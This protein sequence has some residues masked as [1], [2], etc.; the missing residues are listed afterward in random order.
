M[1]AELIAA[2]LLVAEATLSLLT[3]RRRG[4][5]VAEAVAFLLLAALLATADFAELASALAGAPKPLFSLE[6]TER[7]GRGVLEEADRTVSSALTWS[8]A[9]AAAS[10]IAFTVLLAASI[11]TGG[12][13]VVAAALSYSGLAFVQALVN[14]ALA[15]AMTYRFLGQLCIAVAKAGKAAKALL[16]LGGALMVPKATRKVGATLSAVCVGLSLVIPAALN[17]VIRPVGAWENA[18]EVGELGLVKFEPLLR[19][20]VARADGAGWRRLRVEWVD[21][22]APPGLAV[23]YEDSR[24]RVIVRQSGRWF[25][26]L[27]SE[28]RVVG[29][30]YGTYW[31]PA[32]RPVFRVEA[33]G[34]ASLSCYASDLSTAPACVPTAENFTLV[35]FKLAGEGVSLVLFRD[36]SSWGAQAR[37][38]GLWVGKGFFVLEGSGMR[39]PP[40]WWY[41][42]SGYLEN[43]DVV[44]VLDPLFC[45]A[46]KGF[47]RPPPELGLG[48]PAP[49]ATVEYVEVVAWIQG[50]VDYDDLC[51]GGQPKVVDAGESVVEINGTAY[52]LRP[53]LSCVTSF[54]YLPLR[55][56]REDLARWFDHFARLANASLPPTRAAAGANRCLYGNGS[57][58]YA[59]VWNGGV[60]Y[61]QSV[62]PLERAPKIVITARYYGKLT[63]PAVVGPL[64]ARAVARGF[65]L[66]LNLV[67]GVGECPNDLALSGYDVMN[68]SVVL[69][70][71]Y[72]TLLE[73]YIGGGVVRSLRESLHDI[74]GCVN[75]LTLTAAVLLAA[76]IGVSLL[77]SALGGV[78]AFPSPL[79]SPLGYPFHALREVGAAL[80]SLARS[81]V[82]ALVFRGARTR[83]ARGTFFEE[84]YNVLREIERELRSLRELS[85]APHTRWRTLRRGLKRALGF[86]LGYSSAH[87]LPFALRVASEV[88]SRKAL[89]M[90]PREYPY[91]ERLRLAFMHPT[92][93]R[94]LF[95][96]DV[97]YALS[98]ILDAKPFTAPFSAGFIKSLKK[99]YRLLH[100]KRLKLD[101]FINAFIMGPSSRSELE[102]ALAKLAKG[103]LK[104]RASEKDLRR[105]SGALARVALPYSILETIG[106]RLAG[107][108]DELAWKVAALAAQLRFRKPELL[109]LARSRPAVALRLA[110][111]AALGQLNVSGP[112]K[113]AVFE[114]LSKLERGGVELASTWLSCMERGDTWRYLALRVAFEPGGR[115]WFL[116]ELPAQVEALVKNLAEAWRSGVGAAP[117]ELVRGLAAGFGEFEERLF[118]GFA[119]ALRGLG[120]DLHTAAEA[121][122]LSG[123]PYWAGYAVMLA[124]ESGSLD[125]LVRAVVEVISRV[126]PPQESVYREELA[127]VKSFFERAYRELSRA[128]KLV[129][130][131]LL[132]LTRSELSPDPGLSL[133]LL[134]DAEARAARSKELLWD[135]LS[136]INEALN[137]VTALTAEVNEVGLKVRLLE[138]AGFKGWRESLLKLEALLAST[139]S[140]LEDLRLKIKFS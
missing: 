14:A 106:G 138:G 124:V 121:L 123:D 33:G 59:L 77:S 36:T 113:A 39:G 68:E 103:L 129:E 62:W 120:A 32:E 134:A 49:N 66:R 70:L 110:D 40:L 82:E 26:E 91:A 47:G 4:E 131:G 132:S 37:G 72:D 99:E 20:P 84:A 114:G 50:D 83:I 109:E 2:F 28:Y 64:P 16:P 102:R 73:E 93:A 81:V 9:A 87:P 8:Q 45:D 11:L 80:T 107:S 63:K 15:V 104:G 111:L 51:A 13:V 117:Q 125:E 52:R 34:Y 61:S 71:A 25:T 53:E 78:P 76:A 74:L 5:R 85:S 43:H 1:S 24:G 12:A 3:A 135:L 136:R 17:A 60:L 27:A 116:S 95:A 88:A 86:A 94:L 65:A 112:W 90:V 23:V 31:L 89:S 100:P 21:V 35:R 92:A 7:I 122:V 118:E 19:V 30:V 128:V 57:R 140:A 139:R 41:D 6:L 38:W 54:E 67:G 29:A 55:D 44:G 96:S 79:L 22:P 10:S 97:L 108:G 105:A 98:W 133:A 48:G 18:K 101:A 126:T 127:A 69:G 75:I 56:A 115:P 137:V 42:V 119:D 46:R 130:E 58:V